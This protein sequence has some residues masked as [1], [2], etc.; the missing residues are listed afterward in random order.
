MSPSRHATT[1]GESDARATSRSAA[2]TAPRGGS[3]AGMRALGLG[4]GLGLGVGL[5]L[6]LGLG[7]GSGLGL[8]KG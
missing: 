5:G 8:G 1:S 3:Y 2:T 6:G 4:L 7:L